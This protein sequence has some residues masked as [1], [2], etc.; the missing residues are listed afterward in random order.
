VKISSER[1]FHP[2]LG[3]FGGRDGVFA[4]DFARATRHFFFS[5][6][7]FLLRF[8]RSFFSV[9]LSLSLERQRLLRVS[10]ARVK[11]TLTIREFLSSSHRRNTTHRIYKKIRQPRARPV[12][13]PRT[14]F[15]TGMRPSSAQPI[16]P[17]KA[18]SFSSRSISLRIIRSNRQ[19]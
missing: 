12:H 13:G 10:I 17:T 6:F 14:T 9:F 8:S 18:V 15:S 2:V 11:L 1:V 7:R 16:V 3:A 4:L 19:R 5:S